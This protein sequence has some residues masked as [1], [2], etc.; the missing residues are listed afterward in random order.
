MIPWSCVDIWTTT[1]SV[2]AEKPTSARM[3]S[4]SARAETRQSRKEDIK[5]VMHSVDKV[6]NM[7]I[8][9]T[10]S[11]NIAKILPAGEALGEEVDS[12]SRDDHE[13][14]Q[15]DASITGSSSICSPSSHFC[16]ADDQE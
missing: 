6:L 3:L 8:V 10:C 4:R 15:V 14:V 2:L 7:H 12:D 16:L 11:M 1:E 13:A 9:T 5:R